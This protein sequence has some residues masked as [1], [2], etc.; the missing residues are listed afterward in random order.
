MINAHTD[1][2]DI[3][4]T[5]VKSLYILQMIMTYCKWNTNIING[6]RNNISEE[7]I[8][9]IHFKDIIKCDSKKMTL[10]FSYQPFANRTEICDTQNKLSLQIKDPWSC[11]WGV[12]PKLKWNRFSEA[13][14]FTRLHFDSGAIFGPVMSVSASTAK[15]KVTLLFSP[16]CT[17]VTAWN[18]VINVEFDVS[19][20]VTACADNSWA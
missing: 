5:K 14:S 16:S 10:P 18:R 2:F 17:L 3:V 4:K 19:S 7:L 6:W 1:A 13:H 11:L 12:S 20:C 8:G 9:F 15:S